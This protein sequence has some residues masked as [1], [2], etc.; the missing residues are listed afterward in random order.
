[1]KFQDEIKTAAEKH[2]IPFELLSAQVQQES[3]FNPIATSHCGARGLLQLMPATGHELGLKDDEFFDVE[4]NLDAGARYLKQQYR[5][6]KNMCETLP[7]TGVNACTVGDYWMLALA[8]YNG[9][10]GYVI[11]AI[12][13][14][15]QDGL[16]VRWETVSMKLSDP[17][18][19][20]RGRHP[21]ENQIRDYVARIWTK[22]KEAK[23]A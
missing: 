5:S 1:M 10:M 12:N 18:C 23:D 2:Q 20:V 15:L 16:S 17:F 3:S 22:Y 14:C 7:R 8:C 4:K 6:M 13:L 21:D 19:M 11:K 9:G